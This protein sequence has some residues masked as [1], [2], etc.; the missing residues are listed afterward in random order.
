M[1][2]APVG[3]RTVAPTIL[4]EDPDRRLNFLKG[5]CGVVEHQCVPGRDG[6]AGHADVIIGV[7]HVKTGKAQV[8]FPAF[9]HML[10][11]N[12]PDAEAA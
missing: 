8:G 11:V 7:S 12:V 5:A 1:N 9:S 2:T 10:R 6:S 4:G 3:C